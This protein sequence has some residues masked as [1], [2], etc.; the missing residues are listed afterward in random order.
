MSLLLLGCGQPDPVK[1]RTGPNNFVEF[2]H[3]RV[4]DY[5]WL[6]NPRDNTVSE[7]LREENACTKAM[8]S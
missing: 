7:H 2:G 1:T 4:D 5:F 8:L 6:N 3:T